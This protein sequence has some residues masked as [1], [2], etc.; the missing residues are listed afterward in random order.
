MIGGFRTAGGGTTDAVGFTKRGTGTLTLSGNNTFSGPLAVS[1]GVDAT[2]T[3]TLVLNG[4][5]LNAGT[6]T[7]IPTVSI[8]TISNLRL[9]ASQILPAGSLIT[10]QTQGRLRLNGYYSDGPLHFRHERHHRGWYG[11]AQHR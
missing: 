5:N 2:N 3:S 11:Q 8:G 4:T 9:G 7:A 1:G 6:S 10:T